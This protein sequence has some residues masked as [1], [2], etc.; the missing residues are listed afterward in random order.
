MTIGNNKFDF[1][2]KNSKYERKTFFYNSE[3][4]L[5]RKT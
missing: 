2:K 3:I 5:F 1:L 4:K